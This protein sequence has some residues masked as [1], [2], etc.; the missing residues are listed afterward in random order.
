M[1]TTILVALLVT[2]LASPAS[3]QFTLNTL[4]RDAVEAWWNRRGPSVVPLQWNGNIEACNPGTLSPVFLEAVERELNWH[5]EFYG[6]GPVRL[7]TE[8]NRVAQ[9]A[10]LLMAA[11]EEINHFPPPTWRCW[12]PARAQAA[13]QSELISVG[14]VGM[15]SAFIDDGGPEQDGG[16]NAVVGHRLGLLYPGISEMG[17]G[18]GP[19]GPGTIS[20]PESLPF[21]G[22]GR[23]GFIGTPPPGYVPYQMFTERWS[24]AYPRTSGTYPDF[25]GATVTV[26]RDGVPIPVMFERRPEL[27][28]DSVVFVPDIP[29]LRR[30]PPSFLPTPER[31]VGT[32]FTVTVANAIVDGVPRNYEYSVKA[33]SPRVFPGPTIGTKVWSDR[34]SGG[35]FLVTKGNGDRLA[36]VRLTY[37][38]AGNPTWFFG[39]GKLKTST[40]YEG[41]MNYPFV[42]SQG[43]LLV[44]NAGALG[45]QTPD[46]ESGTFFA[47]TSRGIQ[48]ASTTPLGM[49]DTRVVDR[50]RFGSGPSPA[51]APQSGVWVN[52][53]DPYRACVI[54]TEGDRLVFVMLTYGSGGKPVWYGNVGRFINTTSFETRLLEFRPGLHVARDLG[55]MR[56]DFTDGATAILT[57]ADGAQIPL[58]FSF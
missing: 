33:F 23:D 31:L 28:F 36:S 45:F 5:R 15:V 7:T 11:N 4:D 40:L 48:T 25:R 13:R 16:R 22:S 50:L 20:L 12:T 49:T 57:T 29:E 30:P 37:D 44:L 32:V 38:E 27:T 2:L 1:K 21:P 43:V 51:G 9:D 19:D 52:P 46:G 39:L 54:A 8:L 3:A 26:T 24:L 53:R 35:E 6:A 17:V 58:V 34:I 42:N 47:D 41:M 56:I 14:R 55:A 10:A 18:H